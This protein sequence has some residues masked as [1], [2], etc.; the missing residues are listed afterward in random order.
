[1]AMEASSSAVN[2]VLGWSQPENARDS[3]AVAASGM[4]T[5][6]KPAPMSVTASSSA[7]PKAT[8]PFNSRVM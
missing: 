3:V 1:M 2:G 4:A 5:A 6:A 7:L 8:I